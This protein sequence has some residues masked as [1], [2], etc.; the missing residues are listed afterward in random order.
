MGFLRLI[1]EN[2]FFPL[3]LK[4]F[5]I[6]REKKCATDAWIVWWEKSCQPQILLYSGIKRNFLSF[7]CIHHTECHF[8]QAVHL[9]W[10]KTIAWENGKI[11]NNIKLSPEVPS[12]FFW[13]Q[14]DLLV[15][16]ISIRCSLWLEWVEGEGGGG[17]LY[18][19][20]LWF[21]LADPPFASYS[22][23]IWPAFS[24]LGNK[25]CWM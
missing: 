23:P 22:L 13:G 9:Y 6:L 21:L 10:E 24:R 19:P 14:V 2:S 25:S 7:V 16:E 5:G 11:L 8:H 1:F 4:W 15:Y 3:C 18:V 12:L 17:V 20:N